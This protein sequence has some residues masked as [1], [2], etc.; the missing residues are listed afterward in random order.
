MPA[1]DTKFSEPNR[2]AVAPKVR[3]DQK[4]WVAIFEAQRKSGLSVEGFCS[5]N[6]IARSAYWKWSKRLGATK[7]TAA[8][9][10]VEP[11]FM[12]IPIRSIPASSLELELG[13]LRVRLDGPATERVIDAIIQR[14]ATNA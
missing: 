13:A 11:A 4:Q 7:S 5:A 9:K 12:P 8:G 10:I 1:P 14:I 2:K 6:H 3:H